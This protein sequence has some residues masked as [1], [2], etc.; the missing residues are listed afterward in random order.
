MRYLL[1]ICSFILPVFC[2]GQSLSHVYLSGGSQLVYFG[3]LT[4]QQIFIKV[5]PQG[6]LLDF[7]MEVT[8]GRFYNEP[9]R[10][11]PYM[12]RVEKYGAQHDSVFS[13]LIKSIGTCGITYYGSFDRQEL[14]GKIKSIGSL[15]LDYFES[16][17][18][19]AYAGKLRS[20]GSISFS[21]YSSFDNEA[22]RG[23]LKSVRNNQL[24]YYS[25]FDDK[26]IRGKIKSIGTFRYEWYT[27][28]DRRGFGG[29]LKSGLMSQLIDGINYIIR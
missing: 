19:E 26:L 27:S 6:K 14:A 3:F 21:Y 7:G 10:L 20:A 15:Q 5:S 8:Q 23:N 11:E 13:G 25:S 24:T 9:G 4:D 29:S 18:N 1:I 2:P 22:F 16:I 12:G 17:D 28:F